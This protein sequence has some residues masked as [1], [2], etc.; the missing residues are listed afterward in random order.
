MKKQICPLN[1]LEIG[2]KAKVISLLFKKNERRRILDLG[3]IKGTII[4]AVQKSPAGDPIAY[5]IRGTLVAIR[6]EDA[7]KCLVELSK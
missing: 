1:E 4:E 6:S 7:K 2:K 3:I 5:F